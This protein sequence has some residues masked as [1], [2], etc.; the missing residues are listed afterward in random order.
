MY[1][2]L[3]FSW[4]YRLIQLVLCPGA[5]KI[6]TREISCYTVTSPAN[7]LMLDVGCGPVSWLWACDIH[8]VGLDL[9][10]SYSKTFSGHG[11]PAVNGS[12]TDLP[13]GVGVFDTVWSLGLLH[14]LPDDAVRKAIEE[15]VRVCKAG[16]TVIVFDGVYP[17]SVWRHPLAWLLRKID[18]GWFMRRQSALEALLPK[19][20]SWDV[21][22]IHYS[23]LG[24]EGVFCF[25][26]K[27]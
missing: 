14:H 15:M 24:H 19:S 2:T 9:T 11:E 8:P 22:R 12:A 21:K 23:K 6:L 13:F 10:L 20:G 27:E 25:L 4:V 18:R 5:V 3:D 16:G 1:K 26:Q 7:S 17:E